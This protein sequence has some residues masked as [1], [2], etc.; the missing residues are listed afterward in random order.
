MQ[1]TWVQSVVQQDP[2]WHGAAGPVPVAAPTEACA[3]SLRS[4]SRE[5]PALQEDPAQPKVTNKLNLKVTSLT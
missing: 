3:W 1:G 2:T 5:A 4:A